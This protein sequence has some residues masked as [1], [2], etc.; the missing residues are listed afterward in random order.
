MSMRFTKFFAT[1][2]AL[3]ALALGGSA[4]A[5]A[6]QN[7][8]PT[9]SGTAESTQEPAD[10]PGSEATD[11]SDGNDKADEH[12]DQATGPDADRARQAALASTGGGKAT[13]VQKEEADSAEKPDAN[14]NDPGDKAGQDNQDGYQSPAGSAW[15]VEV[16]K[17]DG[18][19]VVVYLDQGFNVLDTTPAEQD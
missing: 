7:S 17:T 3:A 16:T 10:Q 2:A 11:E 12:G 13:A 19:Q 5:G 18:S 9:P 4:L 6:F 14:E 15:E 1:L 8:S